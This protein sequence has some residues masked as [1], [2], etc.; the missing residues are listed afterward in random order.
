MANESDY[1]GLLERVA[2]LREALANRFAGDLVGKTGF[3]N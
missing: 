3:S 1:Q 2:A